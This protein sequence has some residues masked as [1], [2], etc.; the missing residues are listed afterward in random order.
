MQPGARWISDSDHEIAGAVRRWRAVEAVA[1]VRAGGLQGR[2][3]RNLFAGAYAAAVKGDM[4]AIIDGFV[5][6]EHG[7]LTVLTL[8]RWEPPQWIPGSIVTCK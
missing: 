3:G 6:D 8:H 1:A 2:L 4:A 5:G 7:G